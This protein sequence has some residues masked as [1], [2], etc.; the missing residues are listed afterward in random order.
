MNEVDQHWITILYT[1]YKNTDDKQMEN[2]CYL[3]AIIIFT[4]DNHIEYI[5]DR[6]RIKKFIFNQH[7]KENKYAPKC[8]RFERQNFSGS[9]N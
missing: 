1:T 7:Y 2:K 3:I 9:T 5:K 6:C 8:I 4:E